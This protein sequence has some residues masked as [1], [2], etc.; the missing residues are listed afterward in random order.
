MKQITMPRWI[1]AIQVQLTN[2]FFY[3]SLINTAMLSVTMWALV[4]PSIRLVLPWAKYWLFACIGVAI[5]STIMLLDYKF[6]YPTRQGFINEQACKHTNP[7]MEELLS[8][9]R[10]LTQIESELGIEEDGKVDKDTTVNTLNT[11]SNN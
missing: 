2:S 4:A 11:P 3:M 6:L 5:V 9:S 10:R 8:I 1:G 7:A